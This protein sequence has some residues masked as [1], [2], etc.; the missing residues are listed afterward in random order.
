[1]STPFPHGNR[2]LP[3]RDFDPTLAALLSIAARGFDA[4]GASLYLADAER[5]DLQLVAGL[6]VPPDAIGHR[7]APGEGL[8][9]SVFSEGRSLVSGDVT[10]DPRAVLR[11]SDWSDDS[12]ARSFL[13][14]P[15]RAGP[16]TIG[17][18]ELTSDETDHFSPADRGHA[19]VLGDAA[20]L[21]IEQVRLVTE[22][23]PAALA[24]HSLDA[25]DPV[26]IA[27]L[28]KGLRVTDANA[29][30]TRLVGRPMEAVVGRPILTLLPGLGRP[31]ARDALAAALRGASGH[32]GRLST[33]TEGGEHLTISAS[34][35]PLGVQGQGIHGVMLAATDV[36]KRA[37]L[38]AELRAQ[39]AQAVEARDRLRSVVE[40]VSHEL[41]TP[42]TSVLGYA[43]LL[44]D[45]PD[46]DA[47]RR[48][49]WASLVIDKSRMIARLVDDVT[50]LA[51]L[52]SE[53]MALKKA[54]TDLGAL[55]R[56][57]ATEVAATADRHS[58]EVDILPDVP[59]ACVDRDRI[60]QVMANLLGNAVKFWPEGGEITVRVAPHPGG[61]A[62]DV[63]D[64]GPGV[65][66][67]LAEHIFEPFYRAPSSETR[68][69]PGT[70]L[71]LAVSRGIAEAHGGRLW[72]EPVPE[73]GARFRL[74]IP[75]DRSKS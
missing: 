10:R 36:S 60:A 22:P 3:Q 30:F 14:V 15:L 26:S 61:V 65:P 71:G 54:P 37:R 56:Q 41:R 57:A 63:E 29:A 19:A 31:R 46:A 74:V 72:H 39:S 43:R 25:D 58:V 32:L 38:E 59:E 44:H 4:Q 42:L 9:G 16:I 27:T 34:L 45:R 6:G 62:I 47:T 51:R 69:V 1:M 33:D 50:D 23:P 2:R 53:R 67:D 12:P 64:R 48:E 75:A 28:D 20:A 21:L 73:G 17:V 52:G 68:E 5:G 66:P 18:L 55:V 35:I 70:G 8:V 7:L 40:V 11:R 13:G 49:H 24:G